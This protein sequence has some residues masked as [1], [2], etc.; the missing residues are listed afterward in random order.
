MEFPLSPLDSA[1]YKSR[2]PRRAFPSPWHVIE[3]QGGVNDRLRYAA[4]N[5]R[6][7]PWVGAWNVCMSRHGDR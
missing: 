6:S 3:A 5:D 2:G 7:E 4:L 1:L